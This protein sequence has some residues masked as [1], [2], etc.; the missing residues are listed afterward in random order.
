[1]PDLGSLRFRLLAIIG[2]ST[3]LLTGATS[4]WMFRAVQTELTHTLDSRL[5]ASARMV[6]G[7]LATQLQGP[8]SQFD[9]SAAAASP[10]AAP[11]T[12]SLACEIS[13]MSGGKALRTIARTVNGPSWGDLGPGFS[14]ETFSGERWRT[15]SLLV[16]NLRVTTADRMSV[17]SMLQ[18][19]LAFTAL[20]PFSIAFLGVMAMIWMG[21]SRG[22][23]PLERIRKIV[24]ARSPGD[25]NP[26][27]FPNVPSELVPLTDTIQ[28]L[29]S[30]MSAAMA[31]ERQFTDAAAHELRTPL[32]GVKLHLQVL[33]MA[34][35]IRSSPAEVGTSLDLAQSDVRRMQ[36]VLD[37]LLRLA[38]VE[39][40]ASSDSIEDR[41]DAQTTAMG[42]LDELGSATGEQDRLVLYSTLAEPV[43]A[44]MPE[45]LLAM[46]L[47]NLLDNA[48]RYSPELAPVT[49]TLSRGGEDT[50]SF[51]VED[52]GPGMTEAQIAEA[53]RRFWRGHSDSEGSGLGLAIVAAIANRVHGRLVLADRA[54]R[55]GL[56]ATLHVPCAQVPVR[57]GMSARSRA[58]LPRT[59]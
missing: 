18:R 58:A 25:D 59:I 30:R 47:R 1:M 17:R 27:S 5:T 26:I 10:A 4:L 56:R 51:I 44:A 29:V 21:V 9:K 20:L 34:I 7:M 41:C 55:A 6:A 24:A 14:T 32:A 23:A 40:S 48:L 16:G 31:R 12:D 50:V 52:N 11:V 8:Q 19:D 53:P 13:V 46:A 49:F 36:H 22:L 38:R 42:V 45:T 28:Q 57:N 35:D 3:V 43:D 37:Q 54:D 39:T 15:Y 2:I 33:R